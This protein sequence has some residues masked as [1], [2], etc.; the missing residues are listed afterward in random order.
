MPPWKAALW[1]HSPCSPKSGALMKWLAFCKQICCP[2]ERYLRALKS[3]GGKKRLTDSFVFCWWVLQGNLKPISSIKCEKH[4]SL[5]VTWISPLLASRK[6]DK[7]RGTENLFGEEVLIAC[8][9][10]LPELQEN[11]V[12]C[13]GLR[14]CLI[15]GLLGGM[16]HIIYA[17]TH[18]QLHIRMYL[19]PHVTRLFCQ[20]RQEKLFL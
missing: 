10:Y 19:H 6:T 11:L 9:T 16:L 1:W 15:S 2:K 4:G 12:H 13:R 7:W 5:L 20:C 18:T 17:D 8:F 3:L 14:L